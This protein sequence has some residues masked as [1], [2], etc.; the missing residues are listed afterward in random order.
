MEKN[1]NCPMGYNNPF[2]LDGKHA[3]LAICGGHPDG[4]GGILFWAYSIQEANEAFDAYRAA[5][6]LRVTIEAAGW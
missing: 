2:Q 5:G 6:Y 3:P 4:G 1:M